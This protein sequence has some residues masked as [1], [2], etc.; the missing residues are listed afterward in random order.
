LA[1]IVL[2]ILIAAPALAARQSGIA[3]SARD[4][5]IY[6]SA[7]DAVDANRWTE[8][9]ALTWQAGDRL[10]AKVIDW[11][12]LTRTDTDAGFETLSAFIR[13]NGD[14]P[15]QNALRRNAELAMPLN[16][17]AATVK[18]WFAAYPPLT[19]GG[20]LRYA[21]VL[22][23]DGEAAR[24]TELVRQRWI[25]GGLGA[26]EE[27]D[28]RSRFGYMLRP[29]DYVARLDRM[30]WEGDEAGVRRMLPLV[31]PGYRA[32]A[33]TRF[34]LAGMKRGNVDGLIAKIPAELRNDPGLIYERLRW[35]R[36]KDLDG[37]AVALLNDRP[38]NLVR[39]AAW[40]TEIHILARRAME[41]GNY[42]EAYRLAR[43]HGQKDGQALAQAE[44]LAGWLALR[45]LNR[46]QDAL[47]HFERLYESVGAPIS[48]SR[49]AYWAGRAADALG[50]KKTAHDWYEQAGR[51]PTTF[52][53]QLALTRLN[54]SNPVVTIE[55][56]AVSADAATAFDRHELVRVVRLLHEIDP[57]GERESAFLRRLGSIAKTPADFALAAQLAQE[58]GRS[59]LAVAVAK[60]AV[61]DDVTLGRGGYP[62]LDIADVTRP[63]APLIHAL[64]RQ[65]S[66]FN[67]KAVSSAG[68]RGLMQLMPT[69]AQQVANTLGIQHN[70]GRL[71]ADPAYNIRLGSSYMQ[72]LLDRFNGSYVLSIAAY[73]AGPGRVREWLDTFGDPRAEGVD[74][75]DWIELIPIYETRNY[76]Q[77]VMEALHVY[78]CRM[79]GGR[80]K[81]MIEED[82]RR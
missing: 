79:N 29:R 74:V 58:I 35:R 50:D 42:A 64:I 7:F 43:N 65:E 33:E 76:V 62:V 37:D 72:D 17:D 61:Q 31:G 18:T 49:G 63:E 66:T 53:G 20:L 51:H 30:L 73:N 69:T 27:Q 21:T 47:K 24:A 16:L 80:H 28:L 46:P 45:F 67:N 9:K 44:H 6:R 41:R 32:L 75:V 81:L 25:D 57:A 1:L 11:M 70:H 3:V 78:R 19:G 52:Y 40:W 22:M 55:E 56:P 34:H 8:A 60:Q 82:L 15:G 4:I 59:D 14:W 36:R 2:P 23:N 54:Q 13:A 68:A 71:T 10:P 5:E 77:R 12:D 38:Q 26:T 48:R 39:P